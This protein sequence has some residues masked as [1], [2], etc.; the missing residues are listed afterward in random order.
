M[1]TSVEPSFIIAINGID[2]LRQPIET[3]NHGY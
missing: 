2:V 1:K 3:R